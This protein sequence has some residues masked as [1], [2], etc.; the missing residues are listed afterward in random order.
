MFANLPELLRARA[1]E[2]GSRVLFRFLA[3]GESEESRL[4]YDG[5][6]SRARSIAAT[7]VQHKAPG[8]RALLF[9]PAGTEFA[10]A[11]WGCLCAGVVGVPVFP[12]RLHRQLP[13]LLSIVEDS[14]AK[15]VLTT[16]KLHGAAD[17]LFKRAP[18]L[19][20]LE[21]IAT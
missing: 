2:H 18:L 19:K 1:A 8:E 9:Y 10:A 20:N 21:W 17:D 13:R 15:F 16:A 6:E 7:L 12:A 5:L 4:T 14:G 11:F 3:D